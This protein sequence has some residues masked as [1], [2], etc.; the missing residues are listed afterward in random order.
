LIEAFSAGRPLGFELT[1]NVPATWTWRAPPDVGADAAELVQHL[2]FE[3]EGFVR[4][5]L[6][7]LAGS[8]ADVDDL[9]QEVFIVALRRAQTLA[10]ASSPR[11]WL[12]G[13]AVRIASTHRRRDRWRRFLRLDAAE[14]IPSEIDPA[15]ERADARRQ[16]ISLLNGMSEKRRVVFILFELQ[17]LSGE[18][19]AEALG[20][21]LKTVW[22]RLHH[23]RKDFEAA[24][25]R[26]QL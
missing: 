21:P 19:I 8:R 16:I 17:E 20:C 12:Y 25:A 15:L 13:V 3:E 7:R 10:G 22:T 14:H 5:A 23:A 9:L 6:S 1:T 26:E 24:V 4:S 11:A 18:E 2:Y